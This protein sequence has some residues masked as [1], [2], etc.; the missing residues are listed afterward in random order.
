MFQAT[1]HSAFQ[2]YQHMNYQLDNPDRDHHIII[3]GQKKSGKSTLLEHFY[4]EKAKNEEI[5]LFLDFA[6][7]KSTLMLFKRLWRQIDDYYIQHTLSPLNSDEKPSDFRNDKI[8]GYLIY[9]INQ[10]DFKMLLIDNIDALIKHKARTQNSIIN[11]LN[12]LINNTN[13]LMVAT[14]LNDSQTLQYLDSLNNRCLSFTK[15]YLA[16]QQRGCME[17]RYDISGQIERSAKIELDQF[18]NILYQLK[19]NDLIKKEKSKRYTDYTICQL[20]RIRRYDDH[21]FTFFRK[22]LDFKTHQH[23][24]AKVKNLSDHGFPY[25]WLTKFSYHLIGNDFYLALISNAIKFVAKA[26]YP[27]NSTDNEVYFKNNNFI[28]DMAIKHIV[29]KTKKN[30][31]YAKKLIYCIIDEIIDSQVLG[32]Y[33]QTKTTYSFNQYLLFHN[34]HYHT[35]KYIK[36]ES[37]HLIPLLRKVDDS[38]WHNQDVFASKFWCT[39]TPWINLDSYEILTTGGYKLLRRQTYLIIDWYTKYRVNSKAFMYVLQA[40]QSYSAIYKLYMLHLIVNN[41]FDEIGGQRSISKFTEREQKQII[42]KFVKALVDYI[43]EQLTDK[44]HKKY[45]QRFSKKYIDKSVSIP[46]KPSHMIFEKLLHHKY[47][48]KDYLFFEN[49]ERLLHL[50]SNMKLDHYIELSER[51]HQ[52]IRE[53]ERKKRLIVRLEWPGIL[54]EFIL[55]DCLIKPL[56]NNVMLYLEGEEMHHCV[57]RYSQY[58]AENFYRVFAVIPQSESNTCQ[59]CTVAFRH[60]NK[61]YE[62]DQIFSYCNLHVNEQT[63]Q[64]AEDIHGI[65]I[66]K[67]NN[68]NNDDQNHFICAANQ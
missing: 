51:W 42:P 35:T 36:N 38:Y 34:Q 28:V 22:K 68:K 13:L 9:H 32:L 59:R 23:K 56:T 15:I 16:H 37:P 50:P 65:L 63:Y 54:D 43:H 18:K 14:S 29:R 55:N 64:L 39:Q 21:H 53:I 5:C 2:I 19:I 58:C 57:G 24:W 62:L 7:I 30:A 6:E 27:E 1:T 25:I 61:G 10:L 66:Q 20:W 11:Y 48:L 46:D 17:L 44:N 47:P 52:R 31:F 3:T 49:P 4:E 41:F 26:K 33:F 8:I 40:I 67:I 12:Q 60:K 45:V